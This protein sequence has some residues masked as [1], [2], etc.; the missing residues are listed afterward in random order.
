M[1]DNDDIFSY[2]QSGRNIRPPEDFAS[3]VIQLARDSESSPQHLTMVSEE[4][5]LEKSVTNSPTKSRV[6]LKHWG[7]A[8]A[9][10]AAAV[11]GIAQS[12]SFLLGVWIATTAG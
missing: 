2:W 9:L 4:R 6:D 10:A 12:I 8:I 3:R 1:K 11:A 7:Q 5:S